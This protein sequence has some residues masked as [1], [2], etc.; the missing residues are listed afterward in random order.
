MSEQLSFANF[1][2]TPKKRLTRR[3]QFLAEMENII[4]CLDL[5]A[6]IEPHYPT[7]GRPERQPMPLNTMFCIHYVQHWFNFSDS[8]MEDAIYEIDSIRRFV[9]FGS[10]LDTFPYETSI[11][12]FR[13]FLEKHNLTAQ[14]LSTI[15]GHLQ[16]RGLKLSLG[17]MVNATIIEAP[18]S[19]RNKNK[20]KNK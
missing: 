2:H 14:L 10:V 17:T 4:P 9:G 20:N 3:E 15:N 11:L 7:T 16:A 13:H 8:Q 18:T 5:L 6:S 12:N 19:T 1:E